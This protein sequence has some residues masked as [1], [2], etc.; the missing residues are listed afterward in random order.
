MFYGLRLN[1]NY[2]KQHFCKP[3]FTCVVYGG[4]NGGTHPT[5]TFQVDSVCYNNQLCKYIHDIFMRLKCQECLISYI[6]NERD[7]LKIVTSKGILK[8]R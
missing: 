4:Y 6:S 5:L 8:A 2:R 1:W 7:N 3:H